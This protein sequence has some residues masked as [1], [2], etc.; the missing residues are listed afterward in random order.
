MTTDFNSEL[1]V[2]LNYFKENHKGLI[3]ERRDE[4]FAK[5]IASYTWERC[6]AAHGAN[7]MA[8][9]AAAAWG[10]GT[11]FQA[12]SVGVEEKN[13]TLEI[14]RAHLENHAIGPI[15]CLNLIRDEL[16]IDDE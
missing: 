11:I 16:G 10:V 6:K 1:N 14:I 13:K 8:D 2:V 7:A 12:L 4:L 9:E 5:A 3:K 15:E